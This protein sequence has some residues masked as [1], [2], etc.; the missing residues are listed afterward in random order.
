MGTTKRWKPHTMLI[1]VL[2]EIDFDRRSER[3]LKSRRHFFK[4]V[5]FVFLSLRRDFPKTSLP[6]KQAIK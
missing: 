3:V 2:V 5:P 4:R 1:P 6:G